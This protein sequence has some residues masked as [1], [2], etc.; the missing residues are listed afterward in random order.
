MWLFRGEFMN[1]NPTNSPG[2]PTT[3]ILKIAKSI[4]P[5]TVITDPIAIPL[6]NDL[7]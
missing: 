2:I 4:E 6:I 1:K 5:K 7:F 3:L